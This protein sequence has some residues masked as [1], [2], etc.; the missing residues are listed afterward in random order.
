MPSATEAVALQVAS[1]FSFLN[2]I[3]SPKSSDLLAFFVKSETTVPESLGAITRPPVAEQLFLHFSG[4]SRCDLD[5]I[6]ASSENQRAKT[7]RYAD[8]TQ[9]R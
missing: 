1:Y 4:R 7:N 5:F 6:L 3:S 2:S 8:R 9:P